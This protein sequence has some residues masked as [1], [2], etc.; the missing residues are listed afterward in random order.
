MGTMKL[1]DQL[2]PRE[3]DWLMLD[4]VVDWGCEIDLGGL[5]KQM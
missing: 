4:R 2:M 3:L 1:R 5:Y